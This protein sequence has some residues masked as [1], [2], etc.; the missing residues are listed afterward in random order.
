MIRRCHVTL[1]GLASDPRRSFLFLR[2]ATSSI[3]TPQVLDNTKSL[4][5]VD[6]ILYRISLLG[7]NDLQKLPHEH[8]VTAT[9]EAS[10]DMDIISCAPASPGAKP[11]AILQ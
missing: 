5:R 4:C 3:P 1:S 7:H 2:V 11:I 10:R 8:A 6:S 9:A